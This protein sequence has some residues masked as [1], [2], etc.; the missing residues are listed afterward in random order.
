MVCAVDITDVTFNATETHSGGVW[1]GQEVKS[2]LYLTVTRQ[3]N[4]Q[5]LRCDVMYEGDGSVA[6]QDIILDVACKYCM[7][8]CANVL[9]KLFSQSV[10][11]QSQMAR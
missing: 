8:L 6:H 7:I 4:G 9:H 10:Y 11:Y 2:V 5:N 3:M 1:N